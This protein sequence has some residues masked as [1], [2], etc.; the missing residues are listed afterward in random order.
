MKEAKLSYTACEV[1]SAFDVPESSFYYR[2]A[3]LSEEDKRMIDSIKVISKTVGDTY[4]K[5]RIK[6]DLNDLGYKV[7][8]H[9]TKRL[10]DAADIKAVV[11]R[12]RHYYPDSGQEH[13]FAPN[14]LERNFNPPRKN[15]HWVGDITYIRTHAGWL[16]LACVLE[17]ST[18]EVVGYA[19]S[20]S[21]N[22]ALAKQALMNAIKRQRPDTTGLIFHSDQGCQYSAK[23]FRNF[24]TAHKITPSMS[25]RGNCWDNAVMERFF[26]SLKSERLNWL[27]FINQASAATEVCSYINFYNYKRRHSTIGYLTPHEK[28][29]LL[30]NVA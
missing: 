12:K 30:K 9:K 13:K 27:T 25:R 19:T 7:G 22:A 11:P 6:L 15:T 3:G 5:R 4:G 26:R 23:E 16:Y 28:S 17:L 18:R 20:K 1:C 29:C 8:V 21:P 24:L 2:P 14:L 10:M